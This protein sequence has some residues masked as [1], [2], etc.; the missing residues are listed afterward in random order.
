MRQTL[1]SLFSTV[2]AADLERLR[3]L[4]EAGKVV[5]VIGR[6]VPLSGVPDAM[7][8]LE[9]GHARGKIAVAVRAEA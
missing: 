6:T 1:G 3:E 8:E 7:R 5:P 4:L 2:V 9:A